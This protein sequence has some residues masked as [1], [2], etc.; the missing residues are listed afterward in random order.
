MP[1][2]LPGRRRAPP[3]LRTVCPAIDCTVASVFFTRRLSSSS[4]RVRCSFSARRPVLPRRMFRKPCGCPS[5]SGSGIISPL[6]QKRV[7][8]LR[9]CQRSFSARPY[10]WARHISSLGTPSARSSS[11]NQ[12]FQDH[13]GVVGRAI[14][15]Q[16]PARCLGP[17]GCDLCLELGHALLKIPLCGLS[18]PHADR[19]LA[20]LGL[21]VILPRLHPQV[22]WRPFGARCARL[23]ICRELVCPDSH[24]GWRRRHTP[25]APARP[26]RRV[27]SARVAP[28][29]SQEVA[30]SP[31]RSRMVTCPRS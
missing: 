11:G 15:D 1:R 16:A 10:P 9:R 27:N 7:P 22:L 25:P 20:A 24:S 4:K 8:S 3:L 28:W 13:N 19:V 14:E 30:S 21:V 2:K 31:G 29:H 5:A 18:P 26:S 23:I 17:Q 12:T 6:A